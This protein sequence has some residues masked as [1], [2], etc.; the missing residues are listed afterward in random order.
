MT[1]HIHNDSGL[2]SHGLLGQP[3]LYSVSPLASGRIL[4]LYDS[5]IRI[6]KKKMIDYIEN[7]LFS[8]SVTQLRRETSMEPV[9]RNVLFLGQT[10]KSSI[11]W[12]WC[13]LFPVNMAVHHLLKVFY[14]S[15]EEFDNFDIPH[16]RGVLSEH[17]LSSE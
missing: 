14:G 15:L 17:K 5:N 13:Y 3:R 4:Q 7:I 6:L 9:F 1:Q 11:N 12:K 8:S 10:K 2:S 16:W